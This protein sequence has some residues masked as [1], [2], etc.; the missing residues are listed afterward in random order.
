LDYGYVVE[1]HMQNGDWVLF[2]RQPS[3]H[4]MSIMGHKVRV[5]PYSTFRLNLS[6]TTPYN[7]D[8]D[9][10]EMNM[11][12][13]QSLETK[14]EIM[15][16]MHVPKQIVSP[17]SNKP[18]MGIVQ[19]SLIGVKLFTHRDVFVGIDFVMNLVMWIIDFDGQIPVPAILKP[20]PLWSGKQLFSLIL[21]QINLTR[22]T[23]SHEEKFDGP[24]CISDTRVLIEK[25]EL[26]MGIV[27]KRTVGNAGGG[28]VHTVWNE[29]GP[30][31]TTKFLNNCQRLVNNWLVINGFTVGISDTVSDDTINNQIANT[32]KIAKE[33]VKKILVQAQEGKLERQPGKSM[34][35]SFEKKVNETLNSATDSAGKL[36][37]GS[38]S[39]RNHIKNM[40]IAGSK[41]SYI[42]ISQIIACVGQQNV[43]GKRIPFC[44]NKRTLPHFTKDDFGPES[45]GFVENSYLSGLTPQEF[46]FHA[47][48]G[49]EGIIDTA[50]KTSETGYI[51]RRLVKALED[52]MIKY[53][54]T[55]RNSLGHI[56]QFIYGE[57]GMSGEFVED[58]KI[59]TLLMKNSEIIKKFK[60]FDDNLSETQQAEKL[61]KYMEKEIIENM[62]YSGSFP[63]IHTKLEEEFKTIM[64]DREDM[65][66]FIYKKT[67]DDK[68]HFPVNIPRIILNAKKKF[69]INNQTKSD[70]D[71]EYVLEKVKNLKKNLILV[72]GNDSISMEAQENSTKLIFI[73]INYNLSCKNMIQVERITKSA[74]DWLLGEIESRFNQAI[75]KPGDMVGSIAAQ[76]IGEPATQMTLN[77][78]HFAG[79]SSKN[80]TLGVPR[81][82]EVINVAKKLK[83][84]SMT[85]YLTNEI[86]ND[87]DSVKTLQPEIEHT[88]M[89]NVTLNTEIYYDPDPDSTIIE[90]DKEIVDLHKFI[91]EERNVE[92]LSPWILRVELDQRSLIEKHLVMDDIVSKIENRYPDVEIIY[93]DTNSEKLIIRLRM[94]HKEEKMSLEINHSE[95]I[96]K[97]LENIIL[98]DISLKGISQIKKVYVKEVNKPCFNPTTG[99]YLYSQ[100]KEWV[101]ETD[102]TNL[103]EVFLNDKVDFKRTI[104]NDIIEIYNCLGVEAVRGALLNELRA[105]LKPYDVYVNY[106]HMAILCDVMTQRGLLTSIT[107]HGIN[108]VEL[109]PLRKCSFEETVEILLEAGLFSETDTLTGITENIMMGQLAP[110][111]T[112]SFDLHLDMQK[113]TNAKYTHHSMFQDKLIDDQNLLQTPV[114]SHDVSGTPYIGMTPNPSGASTYGGFTPMSTN[115]MSPTFTP[116]INPR[117]PVCPFGAKPGRD[118]ITTPNPMISPNSINSPN[119][120]PLPID[121]A[122]TPYSPIIDTEDSHFNSSNPYKPSSSYSSASS[123]VLYS[124]SESIPSRTNYMHH[125]S[126]Y[127][128]NSL[129]RSNSN[130]P[131][132][133]PT[134]PNNTG[135]SPRYM[136]GKSPGYNF[137]S[138]N[139]PSY[140]PTTPIYRSS[141]SPDYLNNMMSNRGSN[142][143]G[144]SSP[145]G[146]E[147]SSSHSSLQYSPRSSTYNP[148]SPNYMSGYSVNSPYYQ[149]TTGNNAK[150]QSKSYIIEEEDGEEEN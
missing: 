36:V 42:N 39:H 123:Q 55:V 49:R 19:D 84:P 56:I 72:K 124:P 77:T 30:E 2:N 37:Q 31:R 81:L 75:N 82:K 118:Y 28:L 12:L 41:G 13:P 146:N 14:A 94:I 130:S 78:F 83:T 113:I 25:G 105:V 114:D 52:V 70:L 106:R 48:G 143:T 57:D 138:S 24:I 53:D 18:V 45:R 145:K 22:F 54:G 9:G 8:F 62:F 115:K 150:P 141:Q 95:E 142:Y 122:K 58:Q 107:R 40:V 29:Y 4:K 147:S 104:S 86:G 65:R 64:Q 148:K 34:I 97:N 38:L 126:T 35:E 121:A 15:E 44:F 140:S 43:E 80:V 50:V 23:S 112:G 132:Y 66:N 125:T 10:D 120:Y 90:E 6:V 46:F 137:P 79:V 88:T 85:I 136:A 144:G 131:T 103:Y 149:G 11:H 47:M 133:S 76:S 16:I 59:E 93:S 129:H 110:F 20:R 89:M 3:L 73:M 102:G 1:R 21:P 98:K 111:G 127:N 69:G 32:L 33:K 61:E 74:L 60:F 119:Y 128:P 100:N 71:P 134:S 17:Q 91:V 109:G 67:F 68:Q 99:E 7:A 51:Q 63:H 135:S 26:I 92:K 139:N 5:L 116:S 101:I 27:C 96:L 87:Y 117:S 108:R